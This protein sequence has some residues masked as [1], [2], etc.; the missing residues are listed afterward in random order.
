MGVGCIDV[1]ATD[2]YRILATVAI[3]YMWTVGCKMI[4]IMNVSRERVPMPSHLSVHV[5][6]GKLNT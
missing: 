1:Q 4:V 5:S 2:I 6:V 3:A